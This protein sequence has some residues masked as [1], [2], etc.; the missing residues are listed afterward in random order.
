MVVQR[1]IDLVGENHVFA[2]QR[3]RV[4]TPDLVDAIQQRLNTGLIRQLL[5]LRFD[6][7]RSGILFKQQ[8]LSIRRGSCQLRDLLLERCDDELRSRIAGIDTRGKEPPRST[9]GGSGLADI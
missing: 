7:A 6:C 5:E 3:R 1:R 9:R 8:N 4:D 2:F